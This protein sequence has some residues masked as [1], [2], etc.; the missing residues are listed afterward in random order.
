VKEP[1][2][3]TSESV[4]VVSDVSILTEVLSESDAASAPV[5]VSGDV[6]AA[7]GDVKQ[8]DCQCWHPPSWLAT[9]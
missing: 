1:Q 6:P 2:A 5:V 7:S 9:K 8:N 4:T 3:Q